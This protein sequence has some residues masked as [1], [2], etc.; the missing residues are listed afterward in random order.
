MPNHGAQAVGERHIEV[1]MRSHCPRPPAGVERVP[2]VAQH[3]A[4]H[5]Q[6]PIDHAPFEV[7]QRPDV[8]FSQ[9][10]LNVDCGCHCTAPNRVD[11]R[12]LRIVLAEC[13]CLRSRAGCTKPVWSASALTESETTADRSFRRFSLKLDSTYQQLAENQSEAQPRCRSNGMH[14]QCPWKSTSQVIFHLG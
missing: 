4:Q 13:R 10:S 7:G 14:R 1:D 3:P 5:G 12:A 8:I 2:F 9:P 6:L 11:G